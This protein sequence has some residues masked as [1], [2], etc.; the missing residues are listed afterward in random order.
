MIE[1]AINIP[2]VGVWYMVP[3]FVSGKKYNKL[4]H[5]RDFLLNAIEKHN[6]DCHKALV[7]PKDVY[8]KRFT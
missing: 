7:L 6:E 1:H 4:G 8:Q 5:E 3:P 2:L